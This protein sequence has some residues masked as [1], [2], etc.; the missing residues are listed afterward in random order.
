MLRWIAWFALGLLLFL[1]SLSSLGSRDPNARA[2]VLLLGPLV[3]LWM[4]VTFWAVIIK[5]V[6]WL[7]RGRRADAPPTT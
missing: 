1:M 7:V 4:F 6:L 2:A 5:L 3:W